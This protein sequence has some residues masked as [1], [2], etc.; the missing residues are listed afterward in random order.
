[1]LKKINPFFKDNTLNTVKN[2]LREGWTLNRGYIGD[3]IKRIKSSVS[4]TAENL[5]Y[6]VLSLIIDKYLIYRPLLFNRKTLNKR[7][8]KLSLI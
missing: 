6:I 1:M 2:S 5:P 3:G 7:L 8:K 4:G